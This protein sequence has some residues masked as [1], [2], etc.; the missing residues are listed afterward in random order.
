LK[1]KLIKFGIKI[2]LINTTNIYKNNYI[3][4]IYHARRNISDRFLEW[5][6]FD[7][8]TDIKQIGKNGFSIY[9]ATWIDDGKLKYIYMVMMEVGKIW[10]L[11][12]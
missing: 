9:S 5:V 12:L 7:R 6:P 2:L 3:E 1:Q 4:I 10:V 11:N 8:F